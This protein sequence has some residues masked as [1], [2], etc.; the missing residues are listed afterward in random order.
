MYATMMGPLKQ[1]VAA[2]RS[3]RR[4]ELRKPQP[5]PERLRVFEVSEHQAMEAMILGQI[6]WAPYWAVADLWWSPGRRAE[7]PATPP[8]GRAGLHLMAAE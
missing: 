4:E 6:W 7:A 3:A 8:D 1:Q 5:D 2:A